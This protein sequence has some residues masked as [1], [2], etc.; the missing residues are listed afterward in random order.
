[1][2]QLIQ[3]SPRFCCPILSTS[4]AAT[5]NDVE[6]H[7]Q[8]QSLIM[9]TALGGV[10]GLGTATGFELA[11]AVISNVGVRLG[12][13]YPA[14]AGARMDGKTVVITGGNRGIG[15][16]ALKDFTKRGELTIFGC[17][18]NVSPQGPQ[19]SWESGTRRMDKLWFEMSSRR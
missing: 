9:S 15:L 16:E 3:L 7:K 6:G 14:E 19:L 4:C 5:I 18:N 1:M 10:V 12:T 2:N 13:P 17:K 8:Q 11:S